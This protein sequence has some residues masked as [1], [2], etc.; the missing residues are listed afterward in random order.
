MILVFNSQSCVSLSK[1]LSD[2]QIRH[3]MGS[4]STI[5]LSVG[6]FL[7]YDV[8]SSFHAVIFKSSTTASLGI[9]SR[10]FVERSE[11]CIDLPECQGNRY[12]TDKIVAT[13]TCLKYY[14]LRFGGA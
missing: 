13:V 4:L 14:V 7:G 1:R 11:L 12:C 5:M 10:F 8:K 3:L 9:C 2:P 6:T